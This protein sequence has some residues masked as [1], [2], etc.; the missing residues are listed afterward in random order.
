M[1]SSNRF[2]LDAGSRSTR[3]RDGFGWFAKAATAGTFR[4]SRSAGKP[5]KSVS[6]FIATRP[7][8]YRQKTSDLPDCVR[9]WSWCGL[10]NR[11][12]RPEFAAWR[13]GPS[14]RRRRTRAY[15]T[16]GAVGVASAGVVVGAPILLGMGGIASLLMQ[17]PN[18]YNTIRRATRVVVKL[19]VG[20]GQ[21]L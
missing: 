10:A 9:G 15:L 3:V 20:L 19:P 8:D 13:Y 11:S 16:M 18:W 2:R 1:R 17:A 4:R 12:A 21:Q 5:S 7:R 14:L 6:D